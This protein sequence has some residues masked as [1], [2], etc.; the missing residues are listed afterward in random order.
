MSPQPSSFSGTDYIIPSQLPSLSGTVNIMKT[1]TVKNSSSSKFNEKAATITIGVLVAVG[2]LTV[3]ILVIHHCRFERKGDNPSVLK[4]AESS[5]ENPD[6]QLASTLHFESNRFKW[7]TSQGRRAE[8]EHNIQSKSYS[9]SSSEVSDGKWEIDRSQINLEYQIGEG[10]FGRVM[11]AEAFGLPG[12]PS[13]C[14]VAVKT[15]KGLNG[16][17]RSRIDLQA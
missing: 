14:T 7:A 2:I 4:F 5:R 1:S 12:H 3:V 13:I 11:K 6:I 10:A 17:A 15:L 9:S 16:R 8:L